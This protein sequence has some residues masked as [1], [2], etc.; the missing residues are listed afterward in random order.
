MA[1]PAVNILVVVSRIQ[2]LFA[3]LSLQIRAVGSR[4][5]EFA[6]DDSKSRTVMPSASDSTEC[7]QTDG[8]GSVCRCHLS[9]RCSC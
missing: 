3:L 8:N 7:E 6:K 2:F 4:A 5:N 1:S 9:T